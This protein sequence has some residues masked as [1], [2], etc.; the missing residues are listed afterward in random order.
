MKKLGNVVMNKR[1]FVA[2]IAVVGV[3]TVGYVA[4]GGLLQRDGVVEIGGTQLEYGVVFLEFGSARYAKQEVEFV[5]SYEHPPVVIASESGSAGTFII[6]KAENIRETGCDIVAW[7]SGG[8]PHNYVAQ[9]GFAV[10]GTPN[11]SRSLPETPQDRVGTEGLTLGKTYTVSATTPLMPV[12]DPKGV[13]EVGNA[14]A[15]MK[16]IP[17][18]G[19]FRVIS[20]ARKGDTPWYEV[21]AWDKAQRSIGSGWI[22][23]M[24]LI[25]QNLGLVDP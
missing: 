4:A 10:F 12:Y 18:G 3:V 24:A 15:G 6:V 7:N 2:L 1:P 25:G 11:W 8:K 19:R 17:S 13:D 22:N 23:S 16:Q 5:R 20:A 21:E 9:V 14:L